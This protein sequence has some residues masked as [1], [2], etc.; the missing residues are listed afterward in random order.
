[1]VNSGVTP[2][3]QL[4]ISTFFIG[5]FE[6][7]LLCTDI[8]PDLCYVNTAA[9]FQTNT[10]Q[11]FW[12]NMLTVFLF[13]H[14]YGVELYYI[15][16][17]PSTHDHSAVMLMA[18]MVSNIVRSQWPLT[19]KYWTPLILES[20]WTLVPHLKKF[21][22][23]VPEISCSHQWVWGSDK[24]ETRLHS[25]RLHGGI[26]TGIRSSSIQLLLLGVMREL[27]P[28]AAEIGQ[29]AGFTLTYTMDRS[30]E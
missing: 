19:N 5:L 10:T 12:G 17:R 27:E 1:M 24:M 3:L 15:T 29:D 18:K 14:S 25:C 26:R 11:L 13:C 6:K 30:P 22:Y 8:T 2:T 9:G 16:R 4:L 23:G 7:N 21:H 28:I 20:Q